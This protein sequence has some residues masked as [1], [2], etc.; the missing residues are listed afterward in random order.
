MCGAAL[1]I[2]G[3]RVVNDATPLLDFIPFSS[4]N[5]G[6]IHNWWLLFSHSLTPARPALK[7]KHVWCTVCACAC[8]C[9][10]H[11]CKLVYK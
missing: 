5:R 11:V 8:M 9:V 10:V 6:R 2:D 4:V 3:G 1:L 7:D